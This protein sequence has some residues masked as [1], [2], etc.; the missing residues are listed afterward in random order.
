LSVLGRFKN[1]T[2]ELFNRNYSP[3]GT[4]ADVAKKSG[5]LKRYAQTAVDYIRTKAPWMHGQQHGDDIGGVLTDA[6]L[7]AFREMMDEITTYFANKGEYTRY[8]DPGELAIY[9]KENPGFFKSGNVNAIMKTT[10][11]LDTA[12]NIATYIEPLDTAGAAVR[13]AEWHMFIDD[14][15]QGLIDKFGETRGLQLF[16]DLGLKAAEE[17]KE[18]NKLIFKWGKQMWDNQFAAAKA[19]GAT[20]EVA[21]EFAKM[22]AQ[23]HTVVSNGIANGSF[24]NMWNT[25]SGL[26]AWMKAHPKWSF[27]SGVLSAGFLLR[28]SPWYMID[29][30]PFYIYLGKEIGLLDPGYGDQEDEV[31]RALDRCGYQ[32]RSNPC[33]AIAQENFVALLES[34]K[35]L[36]DIAETSDPIPP[37][38]IAF[39]KELYSVVYGT[40]IGIP[41]E[42]MRKKVKIDYSTQHNMYVLA[43]TEAGC[44]DP[45]EPPDGWAG[46]AGTGGIWCT[47]DVVC[48]L[49][50][51]DLYIGT[52]WQSGTYISCVEPGQHTIKMMYGTEDDCIKT[53][54]VVDGEI[55]KADCVFGVACSPV[56]DVGIYP[57]PTDPE[58]DQTIA[59]NGSADSDDP[60]P[61]DGWV[62]DFGDDSPTETG[63]AVTHAY[64]TADTYIVELVVTNDCD[65]PGSA[66]RAIVVTEKPVTPPEP[67]QIT[68]FRPMSQSGYPINGVEIWVDTFY[69]CFDLDSFNPQQTLSFGDGK[70]C[71]KFGDTCADI[72]CEF[73]SHTIT[74]KK[75][76]YDSISREDNY[77]EGD[78]LREW[79]PTMYPAGTT[80]ES[81]GQILE[82]IHP[83]IAEEH[84]EVTIDCR[85]KNIGAVAGSFVCK[86]FDDGV[87]FHEHSCG[88][89]DSNKETLCYAHTFTLQDPPWDFVA[90]VYRNGETDPDHEMAF[91][92]DVGHVVS[93][94]IPDGATCYV[95]GDIV[96]PEALG[97]LVMT[98]RKLR[99]E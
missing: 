68:V 44:T 5:V 66:T 27:L 4:A 20:D 43:V 77:Q 62:W 50:M 46:V 11:H 10:S 19:M 45:L 28:M 21:T 55:V 61:I 69:T 24:T 2:D 87:M 83:A 85:I 39:F 38:K 96:A 88:S 35:V 94:E 89:L 52:A 40:S 25:K 86:Y 34:L 54:T 32:I 78:T 82:V 70:K 15:K 29:N 91:T 58:E 8:I 98:L 84:A 65:E 64:S 95:D 1:W 81:I 51:D 36:N 75:Q 42:Y 99:G 67:A 79:S 76:G 47:S 18:I 7:P 41:N 56:T 30:V 14:L 37:G 48:A 16:D 57:D 80:P 73:G 22:S 93:I 13:R 33:N 9:F 17:T 59:F 72:A 3:S 74:L 90:K 71:N 26:V 23:T 53:V 6:E 31:M 49:F 63:Q 12:E 92:I 97:R 60:I